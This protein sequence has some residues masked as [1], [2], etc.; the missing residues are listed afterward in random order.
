MLRSRVCLPRQNLTSKSMR[1]AGG[2]ISPA[3]TTLLAVEPPGPKLSPR[4]C[5]QG[6][7]HLD[8]PNG[9]TA[10]TLTGE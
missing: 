9:L 3:T 4:V 10:D 1:E 8:L 2:E 7:M 5:P 6:F